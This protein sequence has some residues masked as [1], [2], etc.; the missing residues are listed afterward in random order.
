MHTVSLTTSF[1]WDVPNVRIMRLLHILIPKGRRLLSRGS[2]FYFRILYMIAI[3]GS[4]EPHYYK[5]YPVIVHYFK[6]D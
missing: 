6:S 1:V 3:A 5:S 4:G 2:A